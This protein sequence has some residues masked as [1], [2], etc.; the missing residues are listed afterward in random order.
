[1]A[2]AVGGW[3]GIVGVGIVGVIEWNSVKC[4]GVRWSRTYVSM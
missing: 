1:M 2:A 3:V 4:K